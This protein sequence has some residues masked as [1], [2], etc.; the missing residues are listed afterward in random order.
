M[1]LVVMATP[2]DHFGGADVFLDR[3]ILPVLRADERYAIVR[4]RLAEEGGDR[5]ACHSTGAAACRG[6][7]SI[8]PSDGR[9]FRRWRGRL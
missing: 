9:L 5:T 2:F 6:L 8:T 1:S 4:N 7:A 3:V